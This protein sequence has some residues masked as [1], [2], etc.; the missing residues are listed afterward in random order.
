MKKI[1]LSAIVDDAYRF[2]FHNIGSIIAVVWLPALLF[3]AIIAGFLFAL[4]PH[5]WHPIQSI[6]P[7]DIV[8][9]VNA[10][11]GLLFAAM[12]VIGLAGLL[13]NAMIEV[14]VMERAIGQKPK[15][16]YFYFSLGARVWLM[17]AAS[18]LNF[19]VLLLFA[20][21]ETAIAVALHGLVAAQIARGW[22]ILFDIV[23]AVGW[24]VLF[25]YCNVRLFFFLPAVIVAEKRL[26]LFRSWS[27]ARGNVGRSI[28]IFLGVVLPIW[29]VTS[30]ITNGMMFVVMGDQLTG[31]S[32]SSDPAAAGMFLAALVPLIP[33]IIA[34]E[35]L[36]AMMMTATL[37]AAIAKA[38]GA[39]TELA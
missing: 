36:S 39:V 17:A 2:A 25:V 12:M 5:G 24:I 20:A 1:P 35:L 31:L 7:D 38:Y 33:A 18:V 34:V 11:L 37:M 6:G 21:V 23:Q 15:H 8:A 22:V 28:V 3:A 29:L 9:F 14:G 16:A 26:G 10:R 30:M 19:I 4:L 13:V 32:E 27:L